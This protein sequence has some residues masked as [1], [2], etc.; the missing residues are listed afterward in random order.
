ME[1]TLFVKAYVFGNGSVSS[2]TNSPPPGVAQAQPFP[3]LDPRTSEDCLFL[4]V[5]APIVVYNK[6]SSNMTKGVPVVVWIHG[7]GFYTSSKES[8]GNRSGVVAQSQLDPTTAPG[9]IY[10]AIN[11]RLGAFGWLAGPTFQDSNGTANAAL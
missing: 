8:Q 10:V 3:P 11:Y 5:L 9:V 2:F 4:D 1:R 7:G 6:A